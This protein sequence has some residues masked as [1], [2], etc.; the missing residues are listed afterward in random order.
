MDN[1]T[2]CCIKSLKCL[3]YT[4][5]INQN[6]TINKYFQ[7]YRTLFWNVQE[8]NS[9]DSVILQPLCVESKPLGEIL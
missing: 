1:Y 7:Y 3:H 5:F 9:H 6:T 8:E 4:Q 2:R